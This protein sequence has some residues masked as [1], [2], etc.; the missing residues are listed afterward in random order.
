MGK[1]L[2]EVDRYLAKK[3]KWAREMLAHLRELMHQADPEVEEV[4]K[5]G[6]PFFQSPHLV[7]GMSGYTKHIRFCFWK[8]VDLKD[9]TGEFTVVGKSGMSA[10]TWGSIEEMPADAKL[11]RMMKQAVKAGRSAAKEEAKKSATK[12]GKRLD[13]RRPHPVPTDLAKALKKDAKARKVFEAFPWSDRRDYV[14]WLEEA[15]R[16]ATR[17]KRLEA[18]IA[19]LREGKTRH[20]K[21][22]S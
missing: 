1:R 5:W 19:L 21:Y 13:P 7:A 11:L 2:K 6:A 4:I 9:T 14:Q 18:T 8:G 3:P 12:K 15:K 17:E 16:D 22:R 20:W 10:A